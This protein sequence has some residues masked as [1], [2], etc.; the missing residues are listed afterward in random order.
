MIEK[1]TDGEQA[2]TLS[3]DEI[4]VRRAAVVLSA[5][6][7]DVSPLIMERLDSMRRSAVASANMDFTDAD[8][9]AVYRRTDSLPANVT[10][11]LDDIRARAM[12]RA[13]QQLKQPDSG[14]LGRLRERLG[15]FSF[16]VP[17]GAF[18]SV[19]VLV[20]TLAI[21]NARDQGLDSSRE[22]IGSTQ[23]SLLL[24]LAE[25]VYLLASADELELYENLEFY[26]WLAENGL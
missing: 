12:Q 8:M 14:M 13:T 5:S 2:E 20:T 4:F 19:C 26:Q 11:R 15:S 25:D 17:A 22:S 3:T 9:S 24:A 23:E 16:G 10:T 6:I 21:F 7:A 18:A 1:E